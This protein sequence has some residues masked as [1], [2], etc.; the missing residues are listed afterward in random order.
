MKDESYMAIGIFAVIVFILVV[1]RG[2]LISEDSEN[3]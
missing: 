3:E 2:V 1:I